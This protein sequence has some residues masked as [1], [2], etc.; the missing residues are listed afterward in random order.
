MS[1]IPKALNRRALIASFVLTGLLPVACA[2]PDPVYLPA[3]KADPMASYSH[4]DLELEARGDTPKHTA[5]L[6]SEQGADVWSFWLLRDGADVDAITEDLVQDAEQAGWAFRTLDPEPVD[7]GETY[8]RAQKYLDEGLAD[9]VFRWDPSSWRGGVELWLHLD[10]AEEDIA[11]PSISVVR[12][13]SYATL[14]DLRDAIEGIGIRCTDYTSETPSGTRNEGKKIGRCDG[15][16]W[17]H[18]FDTQQ[19]AQAY[20]QQSMDLETARGQDYLIGPNW[21]VRVTEDVELGEYLQGE[22]GGELATAGDD[23]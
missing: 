5:W 19:Q 10:F 13:S 4:P 15:Y 3:L 2:S 22:L 11:T 23:T 14:A 20:L 1:G 18:V 6:G 12:D 8:W 16:V 9:L 7:S 17:M 21:I